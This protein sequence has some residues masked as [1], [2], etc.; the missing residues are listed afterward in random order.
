MIGADLR[1]VERLNGTVD[2]DGTD[3]Q[4]WGIL[5]SGHGAGFGEVHPPLQHSP[6]LILAQRREVRDEAGEGDHRAEVKRHLGRFRKMSM[7]QVAE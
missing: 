2:I 5:I 6:K 4:S 7:R 3:D 1:S